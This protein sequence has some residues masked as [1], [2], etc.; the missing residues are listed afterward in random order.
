MVQ[1]TKFS[2]TGILEV[3]HSVLHKW[4]PK[5]THLS[6]KGMVAR[7][8]LAAIDFNQWETPEQPKTKSGDDL[9]NVCFF[10]D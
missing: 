7:C 6:Y 3:N 5:S 8:K 9:Y 10:R 4:T 1:L 2:H